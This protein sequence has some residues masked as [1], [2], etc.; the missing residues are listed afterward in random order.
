VARP[1]SEDAED[2]TIR[3]Y[4]PLIAAL[5]SILTVSAG[6][7]ETRVPA[8]VAKELEETATICTEAGGK[9]KTAG[10]V[11]RTDLNGDGKE[12]FVLDVGSIDC[13]GAASVYGDREKGVSVYAGDGAGGAA[14][15]F[16]DSAYGM[17]IEGSGAKAKLWLT[18]S[19]PECGRRKGADFASASFCERPVQWN[20]KTG[21]FELAPLSTV[22][23]VQ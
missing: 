8:P 13:E 7:A 1:P 10:A 22:R 16:S 21:K 5:G 17:K 23:M 18:L 12:D 4:L 11:K 6:S 2:M 3:L 15:A 9:P 19:D 20:A 14:Q